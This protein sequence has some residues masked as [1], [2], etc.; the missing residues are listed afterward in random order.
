MT[1]SNFTSVLYGTLEKGGIETN[2]YLGHSLRRGG[3]TWAFKAHVPG[4]LIQIFGDWASD[5]YKLYIDCSLGAK[6]TVSSQINKSIQE[7]FT[8][9]KVQTNTVM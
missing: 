3:S 9:Q 2:N 8:T 6:L 1:F 5:A 4:E 7:Q